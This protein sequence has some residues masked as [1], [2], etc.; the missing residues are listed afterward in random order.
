MRPN[1]RFKSDNWVWKCGPRGEGHYPPV[2]YGKVDTTKEC[3]VLVPFVRNEETCERIFGKTLAYAARI[4]N[5]G[6]IFEARVKSDKALDKIST[7]SDLSY[8]NHSRTPFEY[9][10]Y[11]CHTTSNGAYSNPM[12]I[13]HP[14]G[15]KDEIKDLPVKTIIKDGKKYAFKKG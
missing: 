3:L 9:A 7:L 1:E 14:K 4:E 8:T 13:Y 5:D 10:V 6:I 2:T 11:N 12:W 15:K